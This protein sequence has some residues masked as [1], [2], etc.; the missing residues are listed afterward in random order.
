MALDYKDKISALKAIFVAANTTTA[1]A[2]LSSSLTS[3]IAD[4]CIFTDDIETKS[5]KANEFPCVFIRVTDKTEEF[6]TLG[7][8][9]AASN[10]KQ[11]DITYQIVG[12]YRK[13]GAWSDNATLYDEVYK[14]ASNIEGVLRNN[15]TLGNSAMWCQPETTSFVG[16]MENNGI[17]IKGV[18]VTLKAKYHF[19]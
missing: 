10:Y 2:D 16:P 18:E 19:R 15:V 14:M 13:D 11:A 12:M 3:R 6:A 4:D 1:A 9:G 5:I 7:A 17:W 8:T